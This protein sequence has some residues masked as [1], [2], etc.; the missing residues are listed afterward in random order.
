MNSKITR[1]IITL[2][3]TLFFVSVQ[4]APAPNSNDVTIVS[5]RAICGSRIGFS[6]LEA[7]GGSKDNSD[8]SSGD[9]TIDDEPLG[10]L[11]PSPST[12]PTETLPAET[13]SETPVSHLPAV[14]D[15]PS[16]E[17]GTAETHPDTPELA[18]PIVAIKTN[19]AA[20]NKYQ[21]LTA[22]LPIFMISS[23]FVL[24]A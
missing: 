7:E 17:P 22:L 9:S 3:F 16:H 23:I 19:G 13:S 12:E 21:P 4:A 8:S 20:V 6:C 10:P 24:F 14:N 2:F 15:Q 11:E 1:V 5:K 18:S